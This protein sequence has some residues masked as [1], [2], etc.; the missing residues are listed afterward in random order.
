[1]SELNNQKLDQIIDLLT[2]LVNTQNTVQEERPWSFRLLQ[3]VATGEDHDGNGKV[4]GHDFIFNQAI[5]WHP[6]ALQATAENLK[7][8]FN[9][10]QMTFLD[11]VKSLKTDD[12]K[13]ETILDY[14]DNKKQLNG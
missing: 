3:E 6:P 9:G 13:R 5:D 4:Y 2:K 8:K 10:S 1:M 12:P 11:Y 7:K 14:I